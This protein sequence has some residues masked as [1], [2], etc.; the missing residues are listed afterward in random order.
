[1]SRVW[2]TPTTS[3]TRCSR[4]N[5][6]PSITFG[7]RVSSAVLDEAAGRWILE[8]DVAANGYEG[9]A[10]HNAK[11]PAAEDRVGSPA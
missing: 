7:T 5:L 6:R 3:T 10:F 9:F 2:S 4:Y 8:T 11:G 1:M